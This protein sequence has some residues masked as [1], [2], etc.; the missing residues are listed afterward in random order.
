MRAGEGVRLR[1]PVVELD[2]EPN[3]VGLDQD[4]SLAA[5][6]L[7]E[8]AGPAVEVH[9]HRRVRV[10]PAKLGVG[11]AEH[12][13]ARAAIVVGPAVSE[14][15][16]RECRRQERRRRRRCIVL[17][18]THEH[19]RYPSVGFDVEGFASEPLEPEQVVQRLPDD[20]RHWHASDHSQNDDAWPMQQLHDGA[21]S[22]Q[23]PAR[24][25]TTA[26]V[27]DAHI[28]G[29]DQTNRQDE[30]WRDHGDRKCE[31]RDRKTRRPH[32]PAH[33]ELHAAFR[34]CARDKTRADR[35]GRVEGGV[36]VGPWARGRC[37]EPDASQS[38]HR[39]THDVDAI[40]AGDDDAP[41]DGPRRTACHCRAR[42]HRSSYPAR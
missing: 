25:G 3:R 14:A 35:E 27:P 18:R 20:A 6:V 36:V 19:L 30:N 32:S 38:S 13:A 16:W 5:H 1:D 2:L 23:H 34:V 29:A 24:A 12:G 17:G 4:E 41:P 31:T 21:P 40:A 26:P 33:A 10:Q 11:H 9:D 28:H 8:R 37:D 15:V 39:S 22:D 42:R 7:V